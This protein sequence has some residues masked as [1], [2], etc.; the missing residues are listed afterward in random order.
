MKCIF[1]CSLVILFVLSISCS[2]DN[3]NP[4]TEQPSNN[5]NAD[6]LYSGTLTIDSNTVITDISSQN[7][8]ISVTLD[9]EY[10]VV[11][12]EDN[13]TDYTINYYEWTVDLTYSDNTTQVIP[14]LGESI[15]ISL[16]SITLNPYGYAPLSALLSFTTPVPGKIK[17]TIASKSDEVPPISH[18]FTN[19]GTR[20][21]IPIYG[22]YGD[23]T[24]NVEIEFLDF[25]GNSRIALDVEIQTEDLGRLYA[26]EMTVM[27]NKYSYEESDKLFLLENA[28][29]DVSGA[30]RWYTT[31]SGTYFYAL[32]D[33]IIAI[34]KYADRGTN[35]TG[36]EIQLVSLI[37]EDLGYYTVPNGMHHEINEKEP[38][39]NLLVAS[40]RNDYVT[41]DNDTEDLIVEIDRDTREVV[42]S[43]NLYEI[44][45]PE[46][47]RLRTEQVND[48]CHLN[49]I[50]YDSS[51]NSL[52]LSSKLQ[53]MIAKIDYNTGAIKWI[54]GNHENWTEEFQPYLLTPT[55]FDSTVDAD[56]DWTYAQHAPR[57]TPDGNIVVYDNG[58]KRPGGGTTRAVEFSIDTENMTVTIVWDY[59]VSESATWYVGSTHYLENGNILVGHG[60]GGYLYEVTQDYE[61]LFKAKSY[62]FYRSYP[63]AFY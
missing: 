63:V 30:V 2:E 19:Y 12:S 9:S 5:N 7:G 47:E 49:S 52:I 21:K 60:A 11:I 44:F 39:G 45:D 51:D 23:Y 58:V 31:L 56:A 38:G 48:W 16:D 20:H 55:N 54:L 50:E 33:G 6:T 29:Y 3:L 34:Q 10:V 28:I 14:Y 22:L 59:Q 24:N 42:N 35:T 8:F 40:H 17:I 18:I 15:K 26:G 46:R 1:K 57:L 27:I 4:A 62:S 32:S 41:K 43:W 61:I 53:Y 37:G 36:N 13:L 25:Y